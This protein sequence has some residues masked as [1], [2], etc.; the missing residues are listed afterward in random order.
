[1]AY[2]RARAAARLR[3]AQ[4]VDP[5]SL[6]VHQPTGILWGEADPIMRVEWSDRLPEFFTSWSYRALP[7]VGHFVPFEAPEDAA[8][9]VSEALHVLAGSSTMA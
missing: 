7:G 1:M 8:G 6:Q 3:E 5:R 4:P 9:A 2:Y